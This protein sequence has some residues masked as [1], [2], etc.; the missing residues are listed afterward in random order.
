MLG[1]WIE[2]NEGAKCWLRV[3]NELLSRG[4]RDMLI[5]VIDGLKGFP[6]AIRSVFPETQVQ[7]CIVYVA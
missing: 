1:L 4:L 7:T 3:M 5:A 6:E 2:Q